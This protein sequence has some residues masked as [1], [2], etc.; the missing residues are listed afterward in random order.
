MDGHRNLERGDGTIG[1]RRPRFECAGDEVPVLHSICIPESGPST[2][3]VHAVSILSTCECDCDVCV[4][5]LPAGQG[6]AL[7]RCVGKGKSVVDLR[8]IWY[9]HI[10]LERR[11]L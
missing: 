5:V 3:G 4:H 7:C 2:D 9:M 6:C 1:P 10:C 8:T 11:A